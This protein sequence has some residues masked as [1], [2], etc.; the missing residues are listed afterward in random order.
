MSIGQ[1]LCEKKVFQF[2][3]MSNAIIC[4]EKRFAVKNSRI[5]GL[6]SIFDFSN[7]EMKSS[8]QKTRFKVARYDDSRT[9]FFLDKSIRTYGLKVKAS[10]NVSHWATRVRILQVAETQRQDMRPK[11]VVAFY[12]N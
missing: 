9:S 5:S 12:S 7:P 6:A 10:L 11:T 3:S 4:I 1:N 2:K 8:M